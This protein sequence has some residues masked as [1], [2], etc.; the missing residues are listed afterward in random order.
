MARTLSAPR[1]S[2]AGVPRSVATKAER[3]IV[4]ARA[5][6]SRRIVRIAWPLHTDLSAATRLNFASWLDRPAESPP[7]AHARCAICASCATRTRRSDRMD[8]ITHSHRRHRD[9]VRS[10]LQHADAAHATAHA[11]RTWRVA[12]ASDRNGRP[13]LRSSRTP[14]RRRR[15]RASSVEIPGRST[16]RSPGSTTRCAARPSSSARTT[17]ASTSCTRR[18]ASSRRTASRCRRSCRRRCSTR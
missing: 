3:V 12:H 10:K 1:K 18:C 9:D 13:Q 15:R 5:A 14:R 11:L 17:S 6:A 4:A 16:T 2:V 8:S 7:D